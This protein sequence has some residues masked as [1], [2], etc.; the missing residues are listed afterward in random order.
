M[1]MDEEDFVFFG[2]PIEREE[3]L[4]SRKKKAVAEA[5]GH[6]RTLPSWKQEVRDEEG[7]RRLHGAFTGGFS[8]G[9]YNTVG[10][11]EGWTPQSF[12]SSR[13]N[14][15]E[16]KQQSILNFLDEDEKAEL[17]GQSLGTSSQFDTF[18]F[19]AAEYARKQ[20]EKEQQQRPSAIPG[21]VPDE[22]LLP[23]T[24]SIGVKLLL[25]MGWRHGHSIKDLHANSQYDA[26]REARKAFLAFSSDDAKAHCTKSETGEDYLGSVEQSI[27]NDVQTSQSTPIFVL[28]PKQDMYGLGYDPYKHAPEFREKKRLRASDHRGPGNKKASL[29]RDGL[30][31]FKSGKAAPGFGIG[32]LEEYDAEDEDVYASAYDFEETFVQ[33]QE[34][35]EPP[36]PSTDHQPKLAWKEQGVLPGFRVASNS[37]YAL[38]RF[39]PPKIPKDFVPHHKFPGPLNADDKHT[40]PPPPE[41]LPPVDNNMKLLIEGVATLVARCGKLFEDLSREKNQSNPIFSFLNGGNGHDYYARKLWEERQKRNDQKNLALDGKLSTSVQ[42]MTAET[43]GKILGERPL[44]R[45][46]KDF[47]SSVVSADV[48]LQFNLSDTFTKP[49]SFGGLPAVEKP[50]K[51][52]PA[53]QER[54]ERFLKEKYQGGLRSIDYIGASNM[55]EAARAK[56]RLDFEAAAEAIE[57]G[58]CNKESKFSTQQ[59][60]FSA[61]GGMQFTSAGLE[62]GKDAHAEDFMARKIYPK[63]EE[64]QWRPLPVLCKRFDLIDPYMGK[65][66]PPPR[67]RSKMDSLIFTSDSVKATKLEENVTANRDQVSLLQTDSQISKDVADGEKEVEVQVEN[68]ERPVDLYKAI[69]SDDSD[70]EIEAPTVNKGEDPEKKVEVAHTTLNRLIA[71]D[72]LESLGKELG[73]E[74]PPEVSYSMNKTRTSASKNESVIA[75]AGN[76]NNL[77]VENMVSSTPN[78]YSLSARNKEVLYNQEGAEGT[79]SQKNESIQGNPQGDSSRYV[80][81]APSDNRS[82]RTGFEKIAQED[83]KVKSLPSRHR[84]R[85]SSSSDGERTR[86]S[87]RRHGYSSSYSYSD[88][89]SDDQNRYHSR[90]KGRKKG[91][92]REKSS[93]RKHS[94]HHKHRSRDSSGRS[95][96]STEKDRAES[97]REKRKWRD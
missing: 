38:E 80:E 39:D 50:F 43:R 55:S 33:D 25:K 69:F 59:L 30:F 96:F 2:T 36:R 3:E 6:L 47:S 58:K 95:H 83:R 10:S 44:E 41:V 88:S 70:D 34:V 48:N 79:E 24:E 28:N 18:G 29:M 16:V 40:I 91:S 93:S 42:T 4:T 27:N 61:G 57:K 94:K 81:P 46:L 52:D 53:K 20:A 51:D 8:A 32:A 49:A 17:E 31:G 21:P 35:E 15:A 63:R 66:P 7:R 82:G 11:K 64:F 26:R 92:S 12:T 73:L 77:S 23:A 74:V 65:P 86:K 72:F 78:D 14:R 45:S 90:L 13:K 56:E 37:D 97:K 87:S 60:E 19:T 22:I 54:F 89:S 62:Q 84:K 9:Y 1:D 5:S 75:N 85:S 71:G 67:M 76:M 68:V